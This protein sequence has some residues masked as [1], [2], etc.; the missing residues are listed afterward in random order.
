[1]FTKRSW[2]IHLLAAFVVLLATGTLHF[3]I[4]GNSGYQ[5]P[6][7]D[8]LPFIIK[9]LHPDE[10]QADFHANAS[11]HLN[12][13]HV[14]SGL[15]I[16]TAYIL[17]IDE[18][19]ILTLSQLLICLLAP[20]LQFLF[21]TQ[22]LK[23]AL[24][25]A[26]LPAWVTGSILIG[27][28]IM[29]LGI[30]AWG[31]LFSAGSYIYWFFELF[32]FASFD[33]LLIIGHAQTWGTLLCML[34][35]L[36]FF[37]KP[38]ISVA[39]IVLWTIGGLIHPVA[40]LSTCLFALC[41]LVNRFPWK[42]L[43]YL[44][45]W[46]AVIPNIVVLVLFSNDGSGSTHFFEAYAQTHHYH[47]L[48]SFFSSWNGIPKVKILVLLSGFLMALAA[49]SLYQKHRK[50]A[51]AN[52]LSSI[53]ILTVLA[54]Q[55]YLVEK[56]QSGIFLKIGLSRLLSNT[57][58]LVLLNILLIVL[59]R[60]TLVAEHLRLRTAYGAVIY[61]ALFAACFIPNY[62]CTEDRVIAGG[63]Q[64]I[65][66]NYLAKEVSK[67]KCAAWHPSYNTE[68]R[69]IR[70]L[71]KVSAYVSSDFPFYEPLIDEYYYRQQEAKTFHK[72]DAALQKRMKQAA[73]SHLVAPDTLAI[74]T[75]VW[76]Q[77]KHLPPSRVYTWRQ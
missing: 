8:N 31:T 66:G 32:R 59:A 54:C 77:V 46:A 50:I 19:E 41:V 49:F 45:L 20:F 47:Y 11:S 67:E 12:P 60:R 39:A 43:A 23:T 53:Y 75:A 6:V 17:G 55:Y 58:W 70:N 42:T 73:V 22:L 15:L 5:H 61:L 28:I 48:P 51:L 62:Y 16:G 24:A 1:M 30:Y 9:T 37:R 13:R 18:F 71:F 36:V 34:G 44:L 25:R 33:T 21:F 10:L 56:W 27:V 69:M 64:H 76:R 7:D 4:L 14:F 3:N 35:F 26:H 65:L 57:F 74:D 29:Q 38:G 63:K 2:D 72:P 40:A 52:L 68:C